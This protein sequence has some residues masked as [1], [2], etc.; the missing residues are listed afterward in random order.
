MKRAH[1]SG[2][3]FSDGLSYVTGVASYEEENKI[4]RKGKKY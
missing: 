1:R 2:F 3:L 4:A